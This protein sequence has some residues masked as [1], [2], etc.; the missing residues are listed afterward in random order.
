MKIFN[1]QLL[2][3]IK[4]FQSKLLLSGILS[5]SS[6]F[7]AVGLLAA[8]AW[9]ISMASTRPPILTLQVAIVAVR[10]FGLGRGVFRY[11]SRLLEHDAALAIQGA[12]RQELYKHLERFTPTQFANLKRGQLLRQSV[13]QTEEIQ[14]IWLR[15]FLP[16]LSAIIA[17]TAG[18]SIIAFL[19]PQAA[20][21]I[22]AIFL[23]A[24]VGLKYW[25]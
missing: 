22:G 9:L 14:D 15:T 6:L 19:L 17:A 23:V 21:T 13:T 3:V 5:G 10:F 4:P 12:I 25:S 16:W 24:L 8:S 11:G 18:I 20:L 1:S 7:M 2:K